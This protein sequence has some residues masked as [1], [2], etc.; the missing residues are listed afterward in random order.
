MSS[1]TNSPTNTLTTHPPTSNSIRDEP[2]ME[3]IQEINR[4]M[5]LLQESYLDIK[6]IKE[7]M[8]C[9]KSMFFNIMQ[10]LESIQG[11]PKK[12]AQD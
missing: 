7:D 11:G 2:S 8:K 10:I 5:E 9:L 12:E 4:Q 1:P 6:D 3:D